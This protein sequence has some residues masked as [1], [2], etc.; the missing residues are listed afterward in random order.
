MADSFTCKCSMQFVMRFCVYVSIEKNRFLLLCMFCSLY[1]VSPA[2]VMNCK[3][4]H[5]SI[6][7]SE[8]ESLTG[9][10][11]G[12]IIFCPD[13]TIY[14]FEVCAQLFSY[15]HHDSTIQYFLNICAFILLCPGRSL[16]IVTCS[17]RLRR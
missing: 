11:G 2:A 13:C 8:L 7:S 16:T 4:F 9:V 14:M 6:A 3:V 1:T 5:R 10:S 17:V 15:L 12:H